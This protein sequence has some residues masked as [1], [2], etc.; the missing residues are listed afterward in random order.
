MCQPFISGVTTEVTTGHPSSGQL[1]E[2]W[3]R[4]SLV[5][6]TPRKRIPDQSCLVVNCG[7]KIFRNLA[8]VGDNSGGRL[9]GSRVATVVLEEERLRKTGKGEDGRQK[10]KNAISESSVPQGNNSS[11]KCVNLREI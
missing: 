5:V 9:F 6:L 4:R 3:D 10:R 11:G 8:F 1:S 2:T 7:Q